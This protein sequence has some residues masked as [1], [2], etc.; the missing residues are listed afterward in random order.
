MSSSGK[1]ILLSPRNME[2]TFI[3]TLLC[4][5][6]YPMLLDWAINCIGARVGSPNLYINRKV[7]THNMRGLQHE[8]DMKYYQDGFVCVSESPR[9][10]GYLSSN[11]NKDKAKI[12]S[13][14]T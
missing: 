7:P 3:T 14:G 5:I 11:W 8:K 2:N 6:N 10:A 13:C 1:E 4:D 12:I 9:I